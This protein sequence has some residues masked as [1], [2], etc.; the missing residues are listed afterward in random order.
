ME[1]ET[2]LRL[3]LENLRKRVGWLES[4]IEQKAALMHSAQHEITGADTLRFAI[5]SGGTLLDRQRAL[6]ASTGL[7]A[8][9]VASTKTIDLSV[10]IQSALVDIPST[11]T[12]SATFV[13]ITGSSF[14]IV[15][16]GTL[17]IHASLCLIN[18][19]SSTN[20]LATNL[21]GNDVAFGYISG[22]AGALWTMHSMQYLGTVAAGTHTIKL[23]WAT[24]AGTL[25]LTGGTK[26][27]CVVAILIP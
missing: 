16:A 20:D 3:E 21:D 26:R 1:T 25:S 7:T 22:G 6:K 14:T 27:S 11:S 17:Y 4:E 15:G 9:L 19:T 24:G 18:T 8:T 12:T 13:D 2:E 10:N 5:Y 23:R